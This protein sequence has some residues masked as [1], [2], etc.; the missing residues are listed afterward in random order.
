MQPLLSRTLGM[1]LV[2][3]TVLLQVTVFQRIE[4]A[5]SAPDVVVLV[6]VAIALLSGP[7]SGAA[8]GFVAGL[9]IG[10]FA[11]LP[12]GPHALVGTL[13][14]YFVGLW[15]EALVTE[16]H[17]APPLIAGALSTICMQIGRPLV[18]FLVNPAAKST[19][20]IWSGSVIATM[21]AL[22]LAVPVYVV[23]RRVLS[24]AGPIAVAADGPPVIRTREVA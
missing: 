3:A 9:A 4:V 6:V 5:N 19:S 1:T 23:V 12:L 17:P 18:E 22:V 20:G 15:G 2:L 24:L 7:V 8:H 21:L 10:V 11:A 13:I 14:G 16:E